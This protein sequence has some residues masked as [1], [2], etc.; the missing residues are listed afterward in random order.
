VSPSSLLPLLIV[1]DPVAGKRQPATGVPGITIN[2][3]AGALFAGGIVLDQG[4][5]E[6]SA[7]PV[8]A[9]PPP[10]PVAVASIVFGAKFTPPI[11][12]RVAI[13][14]ASLVVD[15]EGEFVEYDTPIGSELT[16]FFVEP[17]VPDSDGDGLPDSSDSCPDEPEDLD[18]FQDDDGCPDPDNDED[19]VLD[20][21][22]L[23]PADKGPADNRGCPKPG[24]STT[25]QSCINALNTKAIKVAATQAAEN[26]PCVADA[27]KG[28]VTDAQA[29]L[30]ADPKGKVAK[31]QAA[32]LADEDKKCVAGTLPDIGYSSGQTANAAARDQEIALVAD[33][34]GSDLNAAIIPSAVDKVTARCQAAVIKDYEKITSTKLMEFLKCKKK[35]LKNRSIVSGANLEACLGVDPSGRVDKAVAKLSADLTKKCAGVDLAAAFPG[36]CSAA[37]HFTT[38]V[39][40]RVECRACRMMNAVDGLSRSCDV[41]DDGVLNATCPPA[42]PPSCNFHQP[43]CIYL[44]QCSC[45]VAV[46]QVLQFSFGWAWNPPAPDRPICTWAAA[47]PPGASYPSVGGIGSVTGVFSWTPTASDVGQ[48]DFTTQAGMVCF[49]PE[50]SATVHITVT[51]ST[52]NLLSRMTSGASGPTT[53]H[54]QAVLARRE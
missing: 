39:D 41:F 17:D 6:G 34:F 7:I 46:G 44:Q 53:G 12:H 49:A 8:A 33:V 16:V 4:W 23:C 11:D 45:S 2:G 3:I 47:L 38:C 35:G 5:I 51:S 28:K 43:E 15:P 21:D 40:Q 22:D 14:R 9:P 52:D 50:V 1:N 10:L 36:E 24:Q 29:C 37:T 20:E 13:C 30:T 32:T 31:A 27:G 54:V 42:P 25:Q 18:G 26:A 48:H 19:G